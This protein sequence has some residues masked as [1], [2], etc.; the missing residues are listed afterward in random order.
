LPTLEET[1]EE[2]TKEEIVVVEAVSYPLKMVYCGV[3]GIPPEYCEWAGKKVDPEE[4]KKWL[5]KNEPKMAQKFYPE[6]TNEESK[7]ENTEEPKKKKK[8]VVKIAVEKNIRVIKLK[9]GGKKLISDIVGLDLFGCNLAD[10]AQLMGKKF[11]TGASAIEIEHKGIKEE[12][13]QV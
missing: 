5:L 3:C 9:R 6:S 4:C 7:D 2:V 8:K 12:G 11:G 13:I 1:K 10:V